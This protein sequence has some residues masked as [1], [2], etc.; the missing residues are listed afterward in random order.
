MVLFRE[1]E[2]FFCLYEKYVSSR[3][4][5]LCMIFAEITLCPSINL[6]QLVMALVLFSYVSAKLRNELPDFTRTYEFTGFKRES[7]AAL[8]TAA[9]IS[10]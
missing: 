2:G 8:C 6:E 10:F 3:V 5:F 7:R 1:K 9:L 4:L